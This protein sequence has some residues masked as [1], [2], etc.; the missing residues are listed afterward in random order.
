M[1]DHPSTQF[2]LQLLQG[3]EQD[4]DLLR[5][6][7]S[8][9]R[10]Q[11]LTDARDNLR[12]LVQLPFQVDAEVARKIVRVVEQVQRRDEP[13]KAMPL[14]MPVPSQSFVMAVGVSAVAGLMW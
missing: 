5:R 7:P 11:C 4:L 12:L 10:R 2:V 1:R 3:L 14:E 9:L 6:R 13:A 8:G